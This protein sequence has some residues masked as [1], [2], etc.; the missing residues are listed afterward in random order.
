M[1]PKM[2]SVLKGTRFE[3]VETVKQNSTEMMNELS[4]NDSKHCFDQW[5]TGMEQCG[6]RDGVSILKVKN[7]NN[8][9]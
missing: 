6:N 2:K 4:E 3:T 8:Q 1:I 9:K 7:F 5:K